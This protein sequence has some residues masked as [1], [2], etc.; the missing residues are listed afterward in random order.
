MDWATLVSIFGALGIG[1]VITQHFAG[2]RDRRQV[3]GDVLERLSEV[4]EARWVP[5]ETAPTVDDFLRLLHK[6]ETAALIA[7]LPREAV[8][9]YV[10]FAFAARSH[11]SE[12]VEA[13]KMRGTYDPETSGGLSSNFADVVRDEANEIARLVWNPFRARFKLSARL[14]R[15]RVAA[16]EHIPAQSLK[17][18]EFAFGPLERP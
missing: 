9:Q 18:A 11:S 3:R 5:S 6:F 1:S 10:S 12:G 7:R 4:E 2:S 17:H 15:R 16:N 13:D 14:K 8:R